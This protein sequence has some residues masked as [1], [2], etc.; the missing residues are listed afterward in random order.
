MG[1]A[2]R[3]DVSVVIPTRNRARFLARALRSALGQRG[4]SLEAIVVDD[5]STDD[6]PSVVSRLSDPRLTYIRRPSAGGVSEA[7]N[8]GIAHATGRWIGF[9]DDDDVW[10]PTKLERQLEAAASLGRE[11]SYAGEVVVDP[12]LRLLGGTPPADADE[13]MRTIGRHDSVPGGTSSV[14]A[15]RETLREV[16]PFDPNLV[17]HEDWDMWLRLARVGP[18]AAVPHPCVAV[19]E[20]DGGSWDAERMIAGLA[21]IARRHGVPVDRARHLRWAGW[22]SA[23]EGRKVEAVGYLLRAAASGD[24]GSLARAGVVA[25]VPP[26]VL[27]RRRR[28]PDPSDPYVAEALSWLQLVAGGGA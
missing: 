16:G 25:V 5:G 10:A 7:R 26:T 6:T 3:P 4:V 15:S 1:S 20:H 28:P 11:W 18:P 24:V 17:V 2:P 22:R 23:L 12:A 21:I 13:V 19:T 8:E 9:L 27:A 14:V